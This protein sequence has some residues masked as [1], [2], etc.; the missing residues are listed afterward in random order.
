MA[1]NTFALNISRFV[2]K[3]KGNVE[4]VIRKVSLDLFT[5]VVLKS[6]VDTGRF[7]GNWQVAIGAIPDGTLEL[8]DKDGTATLSR[9]QAD[10]L[11]LK[12]G[13]V[14]TLANN[15]PYSIALEYGHSKQ[16]PQGMVRTTV[17]EYG[18][19][20]RKAANEVNK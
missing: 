14:I 8:F 2:V 17:Q 12:A 7:R 13:D 18:G 5:R 3:A 15:L 11:K 19:V 4:L 10:V 20:V 1:N 16:A 6:P 9:V